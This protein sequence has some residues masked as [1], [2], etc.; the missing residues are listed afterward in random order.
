M[1]TLPRVVL[2][3]AVV[4]AL[5][6]VTVWLVQRRLIYFPDRSAVGPAAGA[7]VGGRDLLLRTSDGLTLGA[8]LVP[9]SGVEDRRAAVL[10]APGNAGNRQ[11]RVPLAVALAA[12]GFTVLLFDYRGYGGNPGSP[13]EDGLARDVR[14]ARE[15]LLD[16]PGVTAD[17]VVYLGESLGAAVVTELATEHPPAGLVLRSPFSDLAAVGSAHYPWLPVRLL[18]KDRFPVADRIAHVDAPTVVVLGTAD[19]IVPPEQ[20]RT[21]ADR[22]ARL[23]RVVTVDGADHNDPSLVAGDA[24]VR[25]V[26]EVTPV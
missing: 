10:V 3:L 4:G 25:A 2:A 13:T 14:A 17:R 22:A 18:L 7:V 23:T 8:W 12:E 19:T 16:Q 11:H 9:P 26:V 1:R 24:V 5:L 21:V 20:S 15:A 6:L